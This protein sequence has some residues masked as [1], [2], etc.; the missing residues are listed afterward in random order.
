MLYVGLDIHGELEIVG[1]HAGPIPWPI[2]KRGHIRA[3]ILYSDLAKAVRLEAG[4]AI[5]RWWGVNA[6]TVNKWRRALGVVGQ[7]TAGTTELRREHFDQPWGH[8]AR[9]LAWAK[10]R[11]P[12]GRAKIAASRR[13]KSRPPEIMAALHKGNVGRRASAETR[14][15]MSESHRKRGT[16][17][18]KA[19]RAWT[20]EED[21]MYRT[22]RPTE[23]VQRTGRTLSA[24]NQRRRVLGVPDGRRREN[25]VRGANP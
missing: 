21:A 12:E 19:V 20:A 2:G 25:K 11:D 4:V 23:V 3:I 5:Q 18:P 22:L 24:V 1:L 13:G 10:A 6:N 7:T 16:R 9:G 17:P 8:R 14:R 15:K